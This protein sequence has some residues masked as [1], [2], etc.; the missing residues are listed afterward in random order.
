VD[1]MRRI[2]FTLT[3]ALAG[4]TC[5]AFFSA[6]FLSAKWPHAAKIPLTLLGASG[7]ALGALGAYRIRRH[8]LGFA[9]ALLLGIVLSVFTSMA[10]IV[11]VVTGV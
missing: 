5:G 8:G 4:L 1:R 10:L 7:V 3:G 6:L 11:W 9:E 2:L